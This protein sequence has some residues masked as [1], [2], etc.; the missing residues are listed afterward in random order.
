MPGKAEA[1]YRTPDRRYPGLK[2]ETAQRRGF[3]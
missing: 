2:D 1:G 3:A